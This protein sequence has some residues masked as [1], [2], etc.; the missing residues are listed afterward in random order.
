[1]IPEKN[2]RNICYE[3]DLLPKQDKN[4]LRWYWNTFAQNKMKGMTW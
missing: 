4:K 2:R 1:M 3:G